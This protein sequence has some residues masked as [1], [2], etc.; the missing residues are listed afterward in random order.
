MPITRTLLLLLLLTASQLVAA[1]D[2][3]QL[4][5]L[6]FQRWDD[7]QG[8]LL[9]QPRGVAERAAAS[10]DLRT[11]GA[12]PS[13]WRLGAEAYT[14]E[15]KGYHVLYCQAWRQATEGGTSNRWYSFQAPGVDGL[16]RLRRG[17]YLH[18]DTDLVLAGG[19]RAVGLR[20]MRSKELHYID[21][22]KVGILVRADPVQTAVNSTAP[23][24]PEAEDATA[25]PTSGDDGAQD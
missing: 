2:V 19:V 1:A 24:S 17:R 22:P 7:A 25:P 5:I 15:R 8:E 20:R 21:H 14:L 13:T 16:I 6:V 12:P 4:E 10:A 9:D 3:Y 23:S 18:I 11:L